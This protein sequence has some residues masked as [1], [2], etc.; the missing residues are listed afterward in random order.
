[1][2]NHRQKKNVL[3]AVTQIGEMHHSLTVENM[4]FRVKKL[5]VREASG[6]LISLD[7]S[8]FIRETGAIPPLR[9]VV[10]NKRE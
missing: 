3:R 8:F 7:L 2:C 6:N 10:K 9:F 4:S 1:M 5:V